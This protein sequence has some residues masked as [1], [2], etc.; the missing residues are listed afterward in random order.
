MK[1][2]MDDFCSKLKGTHDLSLPDWGPYANDVFSASH[3]IN[4]DCGLRLDFVMVPAIF[5]RANFPPDTLREC[6]YTPWEASADFSFYSARQQL[7][8]QDVFY[9]ETSY[10]YINEN[11]RLARLEF[12]NNTEEPQNA[13]LYLFA[14]FAPQKSLVPAMPEGGLWLDAADYDT[15][16]FA[17][18]RPDHHAVFS[19]ARLGIEERP[20]TVGGRCI[21]NPHVNLHGDCFGVH[22]GDR[23]SWHLTT[24]HS[25]KAKIYIRARLE[26]SCSGPL[27]VSIDGKTT[28]ITLYGTGDFNLYEIT[29]SETR[30]NTII[31]LRSFG[32]PSGLRIDGIAIVPSSCAEVPSFKVASE[33]F[34]VKAENGYLPNS[35]VLH[36]SFGDHVLWWD[37]KAFQ[38]EYHVHSL[39]DLLNYSHALRDPLYAPNEITSG[40]LGNEYVKE[41]YILPV[42]IPAKSRMPIYAVMAAGTQ[43]PTDLDLHPH[44]LEKI[45]LNMKQHAFDL[46][47][48]PEGKSF[49]FSQ[50]RMAA[51][52]MTNILFPIQCNGKY[53][54]HHSPDK[55]FNSLYTWDSGFIGL[56]LLELD[57]QRA[58]E[59]L[60]AYLT[61]PSD[62][63]AFVS[64]GTPLPVQAYLFQEFWNR[65][66][67]QDVLEYF[68]PKLMHFY[69]FLA[70]HLPNSTTDKYHT[71]LL[72]TWDIFYNSGGWD[73]LPP[74][75]H[76][77]RNRDYNTTPA[78]T[79]SHVIRFAKILRSAAQILD[80]SQEI[81]ALN[82]DIEHFSDGLLKYAWSESDGIFS[83]VTHNNDGSFKEFYKDPESGV[84][85]NLT[86]DGVMPLMAG[87]CSQNQADRLWERIVSPEHLWTPFGI[88]AVDQGAPYYRPDGYWNG[89]I[90]MPHQW[91]IW[92]AALDYG[93]AGFARKIAMTA[94]NVWKHEVDRTYYT[95]EHFSAINGRGCGCNHFGGLSSPVLS[96]YNAYYTPGRLTGGLDCWFLSQ[97]QCGNAFQAEI[98]L[99]ANSDISTVIF[100]PQTESAYTVLFN[101]IPVPYHCQNGSI[102]ITLPGKAAG[103]LTIS[104]AE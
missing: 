41:V 53:I 4:R 100:V 22:S 95:F 65:F 91:F 7:I 31:E 8:P 79:S 63:N 89:A 24:W 17:V 44:S 86:L 59:N 77:F 85:F 90:W 88:T 71:H 94:L 27:A 35:T 67:N 68:F 14:R 97:T 30:E 26:D 57:Q 76:L 20:K 72:D 5:R 78:V 19:C 104:P 37:R 47:C 21:G 64:R 70:G 82:H 93:K 56:G 12:V 69:D 46:A 23:V 103:R 60:N 2:M 73:D 28:T 40:N 80:K 75:W 32:I 15:L 11:A 92:K 49:S 48:I 55:S 96:W 43:L 39:I 54:R 52:L 29:V 33:A 50:T 61:E 83:Y 51:A 62:E 36:G 25:I 1:R 6:G 81:D 66:Q 74:Q 98:R 42:C 45:Y 102:D 99:N 9:A 16:Q 10:S 34:A 38:R 87:I 13:A 58:I 3:I 84:N 18:P 101:D